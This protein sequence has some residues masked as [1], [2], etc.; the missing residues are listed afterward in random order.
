MTSWCHF[1]TWNKGHGGGVKD[2]ETIFRTPTLGRCD[3]WMCWRLMRRQ[4]SILLQICKDLT[5]DK[6]SHIFQ[7][8]DQWVINLPRFVF[9]LS[10]NPWH[11]YLQLKIKEVIHIMWE[12][13]SL[14][15]QLN[16]VNLSFCFQCSVFSALLSFTHSF[17][18]WDK[19]IY[20]CCIYIT[21]TCNV[22]LFLSN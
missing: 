9:K 10:L 20:F 3:P 4:T 12:N 21:L 11:S 18:W 22:K 17:T 1:T 16:H 19:C 15:K 6:N 13:L 2:W 8:I 14:S 5:K 7:H